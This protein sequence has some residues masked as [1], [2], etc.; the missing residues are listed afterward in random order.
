MIRNYLVRGMAVGVVAGLFAL[1]FAKVFGEPWVARAITFESAKAA[2]GSP[3]DPELV[4]RTVQNTVGL[5][6]G[7]LLFGAA[8]GGLYGLVCAIA[9]GRLGALRS[10]AV[11]LLVAGL[12]FLSMYVLAFL[13]YPPNPPSVGAPDTLDR[14]TQLYLTMI[15]ASVALTVACVVFARRLLTRHDAWTAAL[16]ALGLFVISA[17]L[18]L[19]VL[20]GVNEVPEDF[21]A[22]TLFRFRLAS[23]GTNLVIWTTL[24]LGFGWLTERGEASTRRTARTSE[25]RGGLSV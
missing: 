17:S 3:A 2:D 18:L 14:R 1:A 23:L 9:G 22:V 16:G 7:V 24:G 13:K 21:P 19:I 5:G 11:A 8:L 4:S 10:R 20:P 25:V 12:G 15:V 6:V